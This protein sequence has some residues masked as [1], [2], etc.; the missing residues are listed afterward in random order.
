MARRDPPRLLPHQA[1]FVNRLVEAPPGSRFL[2]S[3]S[4][5]MGKT[6]A[7][8]EA[9]VRL[10]SARTE[11]RILVVA[12]ASL[13][14]VWGDALSERGAGNPVRIDSQSLLRAEARTPD[15]N[16]WIAQSLALVSLD[17]L[18][19]LGRTDLLQAI[20]W[21][22][23]ILDEAHLLLR[24]GR[25]R[26]IFDL[27]WG[28][29]SVAVAVG[30]LAHRLGRDIEPVPGDIVEWSPADFSGIRFG[31][32]QARTH[33]QLFSLTSPE[34]AVAAGI[35]TLLE[36]NGAFPKHQASMLRRRADS[37][38]YAAEVTLRRLLRGPATDEIGPTGTELM[39]GEPGGL[40]DESRGRVHYLLEQIEDLPAD[41]KW[42]AL[43]RLVEGSPSDTLV[44]TQ[45]ADTARYLHARFSDHGV[46]AFLALGER[47]SPALGGLLLVATDLALDRFE[48]SGYRRMIHYDIPWNPDRVMRR[49]LWMSAPRAEAGATHVILRD[50]DS[51][52][53]LVDLWKK[54]ESLWQLEAPSQALLSP[55]EP[56]L[57]GVEEDA[58]E[59]D[60]E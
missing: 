4:P 43:K 27:L 16:P 28:S 11:P 20:D 39:A 29:R 7:A 19:R 25:R 53:V 5:G 60:E 47:K 51:D 59:D 14:R 10:L 6:T 22:L 58:T 48:S 24:G 46:D 36:L 1:A 44:I 3:A 2:L 15:G 34:H 30:L 26:E 50:T 8:V 17:F 23:V 13:L 38:L 35:R 41:S 57:E 49:Y 21:D 52:F 9:C 45:F 40:D 37:S 31:D 33:Q 18:S 42:E 32:V 56:V 54:L 12:P 55:K